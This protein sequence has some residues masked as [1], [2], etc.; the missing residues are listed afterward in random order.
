MVGLMNQQPVLS[1]GAPIHGS[2][3]LPVPPPEP[4]IGRDADLDAVQ[5]SLKAD[6]AV[7]LHGPA[8]IG[9]TALIAAL[10]AGYA[11]LPGGVLWLDIAGDTLRSLVTRVARAYGIAVP[12]VEDDLAAA[13]EAVRDILYENRPL[14]VLDGAPPL[15]DTRQFVRECALGVPLLIAYPEMASGPWTPHEVTALGRDDE[16]TLLLHHAEGA[17]SDAAPE[18]GQLRRVLQ[19]HP[20]SIEIAARQF[21]SGNTPDEFFENMPDLP[22]GQRNRAMAVLMAT[23]RMLPAELQGMV[24]LLGAAFAGGASEELLCDVSGARPDVLHRR[25]EML[26]AR[27]FAEERSSYGEPYFTTHDLVREFA[28]AFL[29]G[30]KRLNTMIARYLQGLPVYVRRHAGE[31]SLDHY[32]RLSTEIPNILGAGLYAAQQDKLDFLRELMQPLEA[33]RDEG[34][35]ALRRFEPELV[36]LNHLLEHPEAADHG[37]LGQLPSQDE[38]LEPEAAVPAADEAAIP[39]GEPEETA[40]PESPE[41]VVTPPAPVADL[42]EEASAEDVTSS[43][44]AE[45]VEPVETSAA[46]MAPL[47]DAP[48]ELGDRSVED[49]GAQ[50]VLPESVETLEKLSVETAAQGEPDA[51][52]AQYQH[53]LENYQAD[54]NVQDEL[55][56]IEALAKLNLNTERYDDVL[57]YLD[58]GMTLAQEADNPQREGEM[59]CILGDLQDELGRLE[60]A[61][62]AYREAISA[63]RPVEAWLDIGLTLEKLG[64]VYMKQRRVDDAIGVWQQALPIFEKEGRQQALRRLLNLLG[65]VNMRQMNWSQSESYYL[66]ALETAEMLEEDRPQFVQLSKLAHLMETSGRRDGAIT[67]YRR[68]LHFALELAEPEQLGRT[69]LAL[70]RLLIDDTL[71]LLRARQLLEAASE[72]LPDDTEVQRLLRRARKR[73]E[74]LLR[75]DVTL[76]LAE[77]SLEEYAR[78][79]FNTETG[80][81]DPDR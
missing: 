49:V 68:A 48:G 18:V 62:M 67:Y 3:N 19:G 41:S 54:G 46:A 4:L 45:E 52:I 1:H 59:L 72:L 44:A 78:A 17:L 11:E 70:A 47:E 57:A 71:H 55:A 42:P 58:R 25:M 75:A 35:V 6:T 56:A 50:V 33:T 51:A 76:P 38:L 40:R 26:V 64:R 20:L 81:G 7:L 21:A 36:W 53:A 10:A 34:F 63:L 5:L 23:Y 13:C 37:V 27:G 80:P 24:M 16:R 60:G 65:D 8:G 2:Q 77:D 66:R 12:A 39:E 32:N 9:K 28:Q 43:S 73:Y 79:A 61:E 14:V 29:R 30:K 22:P 74:R 15:E 69:E 31:L